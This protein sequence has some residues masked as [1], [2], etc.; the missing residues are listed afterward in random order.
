MRL[1]KVLAGITLVIDLSLPA[2]AQTSDG[3]YA[4]LLS[5]SVSDSTKAMHAVIRRN[6]AEAASQ[7][8]AEDYAFKPTPAV[9]SFGQLVAH[10]ANANFFFCAQAT[11]QPPSSMN[12]EAGDT[13]KAVVL[14]ALNESLAYCDKVV[15]ATT[16]SNVSA[17]VKMLVAPGGQTTRGQLLGFNTTHNN[18]HYGNMVVYLRLRGRV[19]P[20]TA[21]RDAEK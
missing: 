9:R 21:T 17:P 1:R 15:A 19:P 16:E 6:L 8:S 13:S 12:Y 7:M 5:M 2:F 20:S 3:S 18:E 4:Q 10:V 14:K 11:N